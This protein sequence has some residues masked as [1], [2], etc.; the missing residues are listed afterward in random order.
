M[1][2]ATK[3][4]PTPAEGKAAEAVRGFWLNLCKS[5]HWASLDVVCQYRRSKIG[6]LWETINV[7]VMMCGLALVSTALFGGDVSATIGFIGLGIIIW[8]AITSLVSEGATT[9]VRNAG[10]IISSNLSLDLY[11]GRTLF[12]TMLTFS[13]HAVLFFIGVALGLVPL[14]WTSLLAL[15]G[16]LLLFANGYWIIT[17][18]AFLCARYRDIEMIV[19]NLLQ[20]AFFLTPVFW[21]HQQ[22]ASGRRF[23]VDYNPLFYFIEII[24]APLLGQIP[25]PR[26]YLIVLLVLVAGHALAAWIRHRMRRNVALFV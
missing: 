16:I 17:S 4:L 22:I 20:L 7:T 19:R 8:S 15:L 23:I 26:Y 13:H 1:N 12:K 10:Y 18:L 6:P 25:P 14:Q 11:I 9:F 24:R 3:V 5:F 21:N 2:A